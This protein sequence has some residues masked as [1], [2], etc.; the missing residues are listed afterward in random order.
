MTF[1]LC[2]AT[3]PPEITVEK[4]WVHASE[5]YDIELACIV[6]GDVTSDVSIFSLF[7]ILDRHTSTVSVQ[8]S[9]YIVNEY[10]YIYIYVRCMV[11]GYTVSREWRIRMYAIYYIHRALYTT[12]SF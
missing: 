4:S 3:A 8:Q 10:I 1:Y 7:H 2:Y 12:A 6:H 11:Y 9:S 5:G